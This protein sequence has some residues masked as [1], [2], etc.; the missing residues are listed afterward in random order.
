MRKIICF[1]GAIAVF[2]AACS[3]VETE[4]DV[5]ITEA[6]VMSAYYSDWD[7]AVRADVDMQNMYLKLP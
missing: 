4:P 3:S 5:V 1:M 7:R 2:L 6:P